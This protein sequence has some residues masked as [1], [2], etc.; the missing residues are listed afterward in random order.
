MRLWQ[1][2]TG[3]ELIITTKL[4]KKEYKENQRVYSKSIERRQAE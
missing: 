2:Q 3:V 4:F 1:V